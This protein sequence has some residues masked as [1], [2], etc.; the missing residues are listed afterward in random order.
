[1]FPEH[2]YDDADLV[3]VCVTSVP[4]RLCPRIV[5]N[6]I[7]VKLSAKKCNGEESV[8]EKENVFLVVPVSHVCISQLRKDQPRTQYAK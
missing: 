4:S 3:G 2:L 1:M 8:E 6:W 7:K 5:Y